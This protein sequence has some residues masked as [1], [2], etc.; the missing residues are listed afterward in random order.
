[1]KIAA[2]VWLA[3]V[4]LALAGSAFGTNYIVTKTA[5]TNDGTCDSDCSIR[6]AVGAANANV[7]DDI[8]VFALPLFSSSQTITLTGGELVIANNGS[9]SIF[10][11]GASRLTLS[12]NNASRIL[13]ST[14]GSTS[15]ISG[16]TL[17]AGNGVSS[18]NNNTGGA[19]QN[20]AATMT[21]LDLY[22]FNN[23]TSGVA[24]GVRNSGT[25]SVMTV[26]R[27][28]FQNNTST[29]SSAGGIQNFSTSTLTV[30]NSTFTGNV[31][32][33]GAVGGGAMQANGTVS[34][35]N[36]TFV[37]NVNNATGGGGAI[38]SNGSL[39]LL[40][41][42]TITGNVSVANGGGLHRGTT[43]VNG[44][45]RNS[46]I[47][48]NSGAAA[49]PDVTN[50]AGG[51]VSQGNNII[52][53]V[54]TSTGWVGSDIT[55]FTDGYTALAFHGGFGMTQLPFPGSAGLNGGQNC[56][57][58]LSCGTNNPPVA[59]TT[60]ERGAARL[61]GSNVDIG[62]A[63]SDPNFVAILPSARVGVPYD[64]QM[65]PSATGF[66]YF[67]NSG[68]FGGLSLLA[69]A[70]VR[71]QGTP[72]TPGI[73][74]TVL[75]TLQT[76]GPPLSTTQRYRINVFGSDPNSYYITGRVTDSTGQP[77]S[78]AYVSLTTYDGRIYNG[79]TSPLG[80]FR[81]DSLP[82]GT[83][84]TL[85][86]SATKKGLTFSPLQVT[87]ADVIENLDIRAQP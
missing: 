85:T 63:E 78:K 27:C 45:I 83:V 40:T 65:V 15:T 32:G 62:A 36:S 41:N 46:V 39:L 84:G 18:V 26:N 38:N 16:M 29:G 23:T 31:S 44:F 28:V 59:L 1:M 12:G 20:D 56:V 4:M 76:G 3:T 6:E 68:N 77:V 86:V 58:D 35:A 17:T 22:I 5:D 75:Q 42:V 55:P 25:N 48:R 43:N 67:V 61:V 54:G 69:S 53:T 49:S 71:L 47:A 70:Q 10:G 21:L 37:G 60:D 72:T 87:V 52:G 74:D 13:R 11:P 2:T 19:I 81:I 79:I 66:M 57:V 14:A 50:S 24:G 33:G 51:L 9:L 80:Y 82:A 30:L 34:I 64:F 73:F 7:G 8:I